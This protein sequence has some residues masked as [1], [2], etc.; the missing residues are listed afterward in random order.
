M[1]EKDFVQ[2]VEQSG[3]DRVV[4]RR[5]RRRRAGEFSGGQLALKKL[6]KE[7]DGGVYRTGAGPPPFLATVKKMRAVLLEFSKG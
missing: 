7:G 6:E 4:K 5:K 1:L 3:E 2:L